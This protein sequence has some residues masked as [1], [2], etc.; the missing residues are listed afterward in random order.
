MIPASVGFQ[1]PDCVAGARSRE[2]R[3]RVTSRRVRQGGAGRFATLRSESATVLLIGLI[4]IIQAAD[5]V[6][7]G[8]IQGLFAYW[9]LAILDGQ[10]WR[11]VSHVLISGGILSLVI[12][13]F[14]LWMFGRSM[15]MM[16]GRWRFLA[17]Y[18]LS[19]LGAGVLML[20]AG[21]TTAVMGGASTSIIGLLA[22][23]AGA[24]FH[25][26]EDAKADVILLAILVGFTA[27][28]APAM[29]LADVGAIVAGGLC[30]WLWSTQPRTGG[31]RR[32]SLTRSDQLHLMGAAGILVVC[33]VVATAAILVR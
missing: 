29:V 1:C 33:A 17:T 32:G 28:Q 10:V 9:G 21:P 23:N 6:S 5:A 19:G 27:F 2:R 14:V 18:F 22:A 25:D 12:N 16:W 13:G 20:A 8:R 7:L 4:V 24:K 30:G 31:R 11:L 15:E 26:R 3:T